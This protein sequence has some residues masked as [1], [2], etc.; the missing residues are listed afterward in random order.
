LK[1]KLQI[2]D[3]TKGT[4]L[5]V[6]SEKTMTYLEAIL[7]DGHLKQGDT[8]AIAT[9]NEPIIGKIRAL[10][11]AEPLCRGFKAAKEVVAAAGIRMQLAEAGDVLPGM[12]FGVVKEKSREQLI[13][14]LKQEIQKT[15]EL[16]DDG[17]I[18]KA[19]SLGTLEALI[20]L[21]R[22]E[23]IKIGKASIGDINKI[24]IMNAAAN[25]KI[26]PMNA[27]ILGFNIG[28]ALGTEEMGV[29]ILTS[30]VIYKLIEDFQKWLMAKKKEIERES[31]AEITM[32]C[33]IKVLRFMFRQ[34]KPA[35]FGVHVDAGV[36]KQG[37][38][39]M[40]SECEKIGTI[41]AIQSENKSI[42][43][44]EKGKDVAVSMPNVTYGRQVR[45]GDV[46]YA[47]LNEEEFLKLKGN[48]QYLSQDEIA[49]LQEIAQIK[50]KKKATWGI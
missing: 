30:D 1:G 8:V 38:D 19:D 47:D 44:V 6:K 49:L 24:D 11:E 15:I 43:K 48:K 9:F 22:R 21:L 27:I 50:R 2:S 32:P 36:L 35:I 14:S 16:D 45:E 37:I 34:S 39:V 29:K 40:N 26:N 31:L 18:V 17:V 13:K 7:Y 20:M 41:K 12:P 42:G 46:L 25:I 3:E 10:F 33:R 23:G 4:V 5:E 28:K